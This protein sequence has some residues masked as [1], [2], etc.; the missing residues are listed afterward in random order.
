MEMADTIVDPASREYWTRH[1][2]SLHRTFSNAEESSQYLRWRNAQYHFYEQLMPLQGF[3]DLTIVDYG[4]GPGHDLVGFATLS[5]PR[6][7]VGLD[8]SPS[9]LAQAKARLALHGAA[10]ELHQLDDTT[11][12]IPLESNSVDYV[13][14]SGVLHHTSRPDLILREFVR[15]LKPGGRCRVMIYN[16]DSLWMHLYVAYQKRLVE[17]QHAD[18]PL[19]QAFRFFTDGPECPISRAYRP[20]EWLEIVHSAGLRGAYAGSAI[21]LWECQVFANYR[22]QALMDERFTGE[23]RDFVTNLTLD[24]QGFPR[25]GDTFA[26]IDA[27]FLLQKPA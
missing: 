20:D 6:R 23:S 19:E 24:H 7:L 15:I 5:R 10:S 1:N 14:S 17:N 22:F 3:D 18:I 13:H 9:S 12:G 16:H 4:C 11:V 27:C 2:V 26:G 25:H 21:S 8:I